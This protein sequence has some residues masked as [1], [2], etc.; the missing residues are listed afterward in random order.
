MKSLRERGSLRF[1]LG[2]IVAVN[3]LKEFHK[4]NIKLNKIHYPYTTRIFKE[5]VINF[6]SKYGARTHFNTF[7]LE[8]EHSFKYG[9]IKKQDLIQDLNAWETLL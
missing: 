6:F 7:K 5:K 9:I 3:D 1:D 8:N 2:L 4:E